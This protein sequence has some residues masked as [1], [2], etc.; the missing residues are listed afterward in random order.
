[1]SVGHGVHARTK[2][3]SDLPPTNKMVND[4]LS[5]SYVAGGGEVNPYVVLQRG[6][7]SKKG[8]DNSI[9]V[10]SIYSP[11]W[12]LGWEMSL[13][14]DRWSKPHVRHPHSMVALGTHALLLRAIPIYVLVVVSYIS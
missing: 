14:C 12:L 10:P 4:V 3:Y 2:V 11:D 5:C 13:D 8:D 6:K 9:A 7:V 1:M